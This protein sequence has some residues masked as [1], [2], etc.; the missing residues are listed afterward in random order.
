MFILNLCTIKFKN[1]K[2]FIHYHYTKYFS[3]LFDIQTKKLKKVN[4]QQQQR[5]VKRENRVGFKQYKISQ[6]M[7]VS[8]VE[9]LLH[10]LPS[11]IYRYVVGSNPFSKS[12]IKRKGQLL[13]I[14]GMLVDLHNL[15]IDFCLKKKFSIKNNILQIQLTT[16]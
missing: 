1:S 5:E 10:W 12:P 13:S 3:L 8:L 11:A 15:Y 14:N 2:N 16:V 4:Q 6:L 7:L 9:M